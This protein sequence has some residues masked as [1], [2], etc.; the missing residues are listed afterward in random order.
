MRR[1]AA[2]VEK[3]GKKLRSERK[4]GVA[5]SAADKLARQHRK[6]GERRLGVS[7]EAALAS[8]RSDRA[9]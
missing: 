2:L 4:K 1:A 7:A 3:A 5:R 8:E 9:Y 6:W